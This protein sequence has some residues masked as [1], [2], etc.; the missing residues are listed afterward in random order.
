[1]RDCV[2]HRLL[3][4]HS[5]SASVH[6]RSVMKQQEITR[7]YPFSKHPSF[8]PGL[9]N[10]S[11]GYVFAGADEHALLSHNVTLYTSFPSMNARK[12]KAFATVNSEGTFK[13]FSFFLSP[14]S[15]NKIKILKKNSTERPTYPELMQHTFFTFH[16]SKETDVASFVKLILEN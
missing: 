13:K 11:R 3:L 2:N 6:L 8:L 7:K 9:I 10:P 14:N 12:F 1:M 4:L 16:E 15:V 5:R